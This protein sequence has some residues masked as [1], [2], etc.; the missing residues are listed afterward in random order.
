MP[1]RGQRSCKIRCRGGG[2]NSPWLR[3]IRE[4][5]P[6]RARAVRFHPPPPLLSRT[7]VPTHLDPPPGRLPARGGRRCAA[8]RGRDGRLL[9][10]SAARVG[11]A[12][13]ARCPGSARGCGRRAAGPGGGGSSSPSASHA[14]ADR[15]HP[16]PRR[17]A[18][19]GAALHHAGPP[20]R[21]RPG[22]APRHVARALALLRA[23]HDRQDTARAAP[24]RARSRVGWPLQNDIG[25]TSSPSARGVWGS[26]QK[27]RGV[28]LSQALAGPVPSAL[29]G[30]TALFGMGR[31]VSP[32][33]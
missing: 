4:Q 23:A 30:I 15:A 10:R 27:S 12:H 8:T 19:P 25:T 18:A 28:L 17:R 11:R 13:D 2:A 20:R 29:R 32:S 5:T 21:R 1:R 33:P 31:G 16:A 6:P 9:R 14:T 7:H 24:S 22:I 26:K 3:A